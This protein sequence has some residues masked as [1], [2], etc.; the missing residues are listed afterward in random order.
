MSYS[1]LYEPESKFWKLYVILLNFKSVAFSF[2]IYVLVSGPVKTNKK[3]FQQLGL[4]T[5]PPKKGYFSFFP[6]ALNK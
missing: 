2:Y 1:L 4:P 6:I 5:P 3:R